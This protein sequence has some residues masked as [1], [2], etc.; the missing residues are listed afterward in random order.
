MA[1]GEGIK[2]C[3]VAFERLL[4]GKPEVPAHVGIDPSKITRG[5]VSVEAG[6]DRGYLKKNRPSHKALVAR[7][8]AHGAEIGKSNE[9]QREQLR[10]AKNKAQAAIDSKAEMKLQLDKV[11][12]QNLMLVERVRELEDALKKYQNVTPLHK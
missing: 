8:E 4:A 10:R 11:L 3:E 12:T 7:I 5:I 2:A 6:F 9:G 1:Q